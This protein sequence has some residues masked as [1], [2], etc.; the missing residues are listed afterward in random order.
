VVL[1]LKHQRS[2]PPGTGGGPLDPEVVKI[3][4]SLADAL[5]TQYGAKQVSI[6]NN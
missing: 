5:R 6:K 1:N 3:S 2:Q 4:D